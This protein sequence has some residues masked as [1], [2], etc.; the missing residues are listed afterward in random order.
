MFISF[1]RSLVYLFL[2]FLK[3]NVEQSR[4]ILIFYYI[5][6]RQDKS[7]NIILSRTVCR[8]IGI[9]CRP[10][11]AYCA[12]HDTQNSLTIDYLVGDD[13]KIMEEMQNDSIWWV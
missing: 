3:I 13:G 12:A 7:I 4:C 6:D 1:N 2:T 8:A 9:P 5:M 10:V 11:T